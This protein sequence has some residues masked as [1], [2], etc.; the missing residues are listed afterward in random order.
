M[1]TLFSYKLIANTL[2]KREILPK[3]IVN[4]FKKLKKIKTN[5]FNNNFEHKNRA[6]NNSIEVIKC[7]NKI[8]LSN[9]F[10]HSFYFLFDRSLEINK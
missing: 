2:I 5:Y 8:K 10:S 3:A 7:R 6:F 4:A 1:I 9:G